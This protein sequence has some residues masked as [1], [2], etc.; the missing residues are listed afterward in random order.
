MS[1]HNPDGTTEHYLAQPGEIRM[2]YDKLMALMPTAQDKVALHV[3]F[4]MSRE[5]RH[6]EYAEL[7][8]QFGTYGIECF[9][10]LMCTLPINDLD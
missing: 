5:V 7:Q 6:E 10:Q 4:H 8:K 2:S 9:H 1:I 3:M